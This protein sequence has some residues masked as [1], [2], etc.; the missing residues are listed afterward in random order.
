MIMLMSRYFNRVR[1]GL[2][3]Y[4]KPLLFGG[5]GLGVLMLPLVTKAGAISNFVLGVVAFIFEMLARLMGFIM[6]MEVEALIQVAQYSNFV[7]PGPLAVQTGWVVTRDLANMFFIL[8]LLIIA[9]ATILSYEEYNYRKLLPRLLIMAVVINFSKTITG[10][11]IDFGQVIMLTFVNGF[12]E[13]A[14]GNF[15]NAFQVNKLLSLA[16]KGSIN[17][18]SL[19]LAMALA[20]IM[21]ATA[22]AVVLVMLIMLLFRVVMLWILIILSPLAFLASTFP[23]AQPYYKKWWADLRQ[24]VIS[25][26]IIAF[27]LW[28]ALFTAQNSTNGN[29]AAGEGFSQLPSAAQRE[30]QAGQTKYKIPSDAGESDVLLSM[31]IITA[32][33]FGGLKVAIESGTLGSGVGKAIQAGA[34]KYAK[35]AAYGTARF[36]GRQALKPVRGIAANTLSGTGR[37][38]SRITGGRLGTGMA[39]QGDRMKSRLAQER[40]RLFGTKGERSAINP[41]ATGRQLRGKGIGGAGS[42]TRNSFLEDAELMNKNTNA[43]EG[44]L[45]EGRQNRQ[46]NYADH[47]SKLREIADAGGLDAEKAQQ[48]LEESDKKNWNLLSDKPSKEGEKSDQQKAIESMK[49]EE[50]AKNVK[51]AD[52]SGA[53]NHA[54]A[55][56]IE[57]AQN[58]SKEHREALIGELTSPETPDERDEAFQ[59]IASKKGFKIENLNPEVFVQVEAA[60][61]EAIKQ[62]DR[63]PTL[64]KKLGESPE[65]RNAMK[66]DLNKALSDATKAGDTAAQASASMRAL[67]FGAI[68]SISEPRQRAIGQHVS[69]GKMAEYVRNA[70]QDSETINASLNLAVDAK[71]KYGTPDEAKRVKRHNALGERVSAEVKNAV[72][73][74]SS[75]AGEAAQSA[76]SAQAASNTRGPSGT[77]EVDLGEDDNEPPI[78]LA[79]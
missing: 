2:K 66:E 38:L 73:D 41:S 36:A 69:V 43:M 25:G 15:F 44:L 76:A 28:L 9:F 17:Q 54:S 3:R 79:T 27:F 12:K 49:P 56:Q 40:A 57:A 71:V 26:P 37:G 13:A 33:L 55:N 1:S 23:A 11:F 29:I 65:V 39:V 62:M 48:I 68:D 74:A 53:L 63:N 77:R 32:L 51:P 75:A 52:L 5:V 59:R 21:L 16:D 45:G 14:G 78:E 10:I 70:P 30:V 31:V 6:L 58:D 67:Q 8:I 72:A 61:K 22:A 18:G 34:A 19:A 7:A 42:P 4:R 35:R 47:R 20:F 64:A 24:Y 46:R 60:R 50:F